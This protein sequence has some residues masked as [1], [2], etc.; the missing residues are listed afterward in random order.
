MIKEALE[1]LSKLQT[2]KNPITHVV[3]SVPYAVKQDGTLDLPVRKPDLR[4]APAILQ[5]GALTGLVDAYKSMNLS[6]VALHIKSPT[7]VEIVDIKADEEFGKR[8]TRV[9]AEYVSETAF[10]FAKFYVPETFL[11]AFRASFLFNENAVL[12]QKLCST[13]TAGQN[14]AVSDDGISQEVVA[15]EG[16]VTKS[17]ITLPA[18]GVPL[19]PWRTF[20]EANPVESKFLLRMKGVKDSLPGIALFEIDAKWKNDTILSIRKYLEEQLPGATI[21]A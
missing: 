14:I 10:E 21:I 5:V 15:T 4:N 8:Y 12:V 17:K 16:T 19:I 11:L 20:R 1:F 7:L 13:V 6:G 9:R 18:E 3:E 2:P